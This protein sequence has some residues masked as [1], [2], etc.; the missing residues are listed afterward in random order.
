MTA[1]RFTHTHRFAAPVAALW[2][3]VEDLESWPDHTPTMSSVTRIDDGPLRVGSRATVTQPG[4]GARTWTVTEMAPARRFAWETTLGR[5]RLHAAHDLAEDGPDGSTQTL[6]LD[7]EGWGAGLLGLLT[8][9][10][11]RRSL[12]RENEGFAAALRDAGALR[13]S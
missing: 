9:R 8:G 3:V 11:M 4:L 6:T 13:E 1:R 12:A 10:Q 2:T 7:L 5:I